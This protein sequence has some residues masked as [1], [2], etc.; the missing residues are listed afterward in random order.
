MP[1]TLGIYPQSTTDGRRI[2]VEIIRPLQ[3]YRQSLTTTPGAVLAL[4][5]SAEI[6]IAHATVGA[7]V[8]FGG[9]VALIASGANLADAIYLPAN[10][11]I[12]I[13][14]N[15]RLSFS[16]VAIV[17]TGELFITHIQKWKDMRKQTQFDRN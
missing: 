11:S 15:G 1:D 12:I 14:L 7:L 16:G 3:V 2:P 4:P 5:A 17:G 10:Q 9:A 13:D 8:R 6:V